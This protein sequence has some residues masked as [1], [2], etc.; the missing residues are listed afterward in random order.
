MLLRLSVVL[1]VIGVVS[2]KYIDMYISHD[3]SLGVCLSKSSQIVS[4]SRGAIVFFS[5]RCFPPFSARWGVGI[6]H[7]VI[8]MFGFSGVMISI[9]SIHDY[10]S[11][12]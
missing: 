9:T 5:K 2:M 3:R 7:D 12:P 8:L 1:K 6:G 10:V 11:R 4:K